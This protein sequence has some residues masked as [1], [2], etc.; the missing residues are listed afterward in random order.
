MKGNLVTGLR[1][2]NWETKHA[3]A[4]QLASRD[5]VAIMEKRCDNPRLLE[6]LRQM[7]AG[8]YRE[9]NKLTV[10]EEGTV[11]EEE[12]GATIVPECEAVDHEVLT[13]KVEQDRHDDVGQQVQSPNNV[14][15]LE[16]VEENDVTERQRRRV[17]LDLGH[18]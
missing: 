10:I 7:Q 1:I 6:T 12:C 17:P 3:S 13:T 9:E 5:I 8:K 18:G 16:E 2:A 11:T 15:V 4:F 14:E